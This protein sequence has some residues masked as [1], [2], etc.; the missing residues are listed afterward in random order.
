MILL[1][2]SSCGILNISKSGSNVDVY[3]NYSEDLSSKRIK[4][5]ELPDPSI[6]SE[7]DEVTPSVDQELERAMQGIVEENKKNMFYNGF[8]ILVYS[9]VDRELAFETRNNIYSEFP[10]IQANMEYQQP[11]YLVKIGKYINRIEALSMYEKINENFPSARIV[12]DKF[13]KDQDQ[14]KEEEKIDNVDR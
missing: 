14:R 10:D 12:P 13:L 11:R 7:N 9:G 1:L 5:D 3:E 2:A 8:S 6:P 4:F